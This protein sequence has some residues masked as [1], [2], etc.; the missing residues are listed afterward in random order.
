[1]A[2]PALST[3][4]YKRPIFALH[5]LST[6]PLAIVVEPD[7]RIDDTTPWPNPWLTPV[8]LRTS[9]C[10]DSSIICTVAVVLT[11]VVLSFILL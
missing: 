5:S 4:P 3:Q 2:S 7:Q 9:N 6:V 10:H 11:V 8:I 1:M